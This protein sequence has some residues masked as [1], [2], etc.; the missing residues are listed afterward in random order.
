MVV[1]N[2]FNVNNKQVT[3][4]ADIIENMSANDVS[5]DNSIQYN[6][7]TVGEKLSELEGNV[8]DMNELIK[9]VVEEKNTPSSMNDAYNPEINLNYSKSNFV[10][11]T[12][13]ATEDTA[14]TS[15]IV[16]VAKVSGVTKQYLKLLEVEKQ[17][18]RVICVYISSPIEFTTPEGVFEDVEVILDSPFVVHS[19]KMVAA[20]ADSSWLGNQTAHPSRREY[21]RNNLSYCD[22]NT[23]STS[24]EGNRNTLLTSIPSAICQTS[25]WLY[26]NKKA[27][28]DFV[29]KDEVYTKDETYSK[30]E[31]YT[32]DEV[33]SLAPKIPSSITINGYPIRYE[34]GR[35]YKG[36]EI[37]DKYIRTKDFVWLSRGTKL[38]FGGSISGVLLQRYNDDMEW[39]EEVRYENEIQNDGLYKW[40]CETPSYITF[41]FAE[42]ANG[43]SWVRFEDPQIYNK[44]SLDAINFASTQVNPYIVTEDKFKMTHV[45]NFQFENDGYNLWLAFLCDENTTEESENNL[46]SY[47]S[48]RLINP[49][50]RVTLKE[51]T[52]KVGDS[53]GSY[54]QQGKAPYCPYIN[55]IGNDLIVQFWA[56]VSNEL[57]LAR[58]KVNKETLELIDYSP[59]FIRNSETSYVLNTSNLRKVYKAYTGNECDEL[60]HLDMTTHWKFYNGKYYSVINS[61]F[62]TELTPNKYYSLFV[63]STDCITWDIECCLD[64]FTCEACLEIKNGKA[65]VT[66]RAG[67]MRIVQID[68]ETKAIKQIPIP[69]ASGLKPAIYN[70]KGKLVLATNITSTAEQTHNRNNMGLFV[71]GEDLSVELRS[72]IITYHGMHYPDF[73]SNGRELYMSWSEDRRNIG[74]A[75]VRSNIGFAEIHV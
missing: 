27:L 37:N 10:M 49:Y 9:S 66:T 4:G 57:T 70:Y 14:I 58:F 7:N 55:L 73:G 62:A 59:M 35:Y 52:F 63:S 67:G 45:S 5:Y 12:E 39:Q 21:Y 6:E 61:V 31:V 38:D 34:V 47:I 1:V 43:C 75:N 30:N 71:V 74:R 16:R 54:N 72:R 13:E 11:W 64:F 60:D 69:L 28:K 25:I 50:T 51:K 23:I 40:Y 41:D 19:G 18:T 8:G 3:L 46:T 48:I 56:F 29:E 20:I 44:A 53:I 33:D 36:Q 15:M 26:S 17:G 42:M 24:S 68:I 65:Y 2:K 22:Y 32:K